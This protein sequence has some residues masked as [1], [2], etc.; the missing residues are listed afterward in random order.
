MQG[1]LVALSPKAVFFSMHL[2]VYV[3]NLI[4][5]V[6]HDLMSLGRLRSVRVLGL[7][8][9]GIALL[10]TGRGTAMRDCQ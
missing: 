10:A 3:P 5:V 7:I 4:F 6:V 8:V 2:Q 1:A 9:Y